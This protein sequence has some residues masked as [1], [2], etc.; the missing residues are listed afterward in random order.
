[1]KKLLL[2]SGLLLLA[3]CHSKFEGKLDV[4]EQLKLKSKNG[5]TVILSEGEQQAK[6]TVKSRSKIVLE[7]SNNKFPFEIVLSEGEYPYTLT[8]AYKGILSLRPGEYNVRA[9]DLNQPYDLNIKVDKTE[10]QTDTISETISCIPWLASRSEMHPDYPKI[11]KMIVD[12]HNIVIKTDLVIELVSPE[13]SKIVSTYQGE[14][15]TIKKK[16]YEKF[17]TCEVE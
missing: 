6:V 10:I 11:G 9:E 12:Y 5:N 4:A 17:Y 1:M 2:L 14:N 15:T 7:T 3:S 13:T 8:L 16:V